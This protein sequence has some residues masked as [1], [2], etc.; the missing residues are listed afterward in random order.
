MMLLM[1]ICEA[2]YWQSLI[3]QGLKNSVTSW[4]QTKHSN[5]KD[6]ML[7]SI[8]EAL[9]RQSLIVQG[10]KAAAL[11]ANLKMRI[12]QRLTVLFVKRIYAYMCCQSLIAQGHKAATLS[13]K[14]SI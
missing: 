3:V 6:H 12:I 10:Y 7:A 9:W 14:S 1:Y 5:C 13:S 4:Q 11:S 2:L 8:Y